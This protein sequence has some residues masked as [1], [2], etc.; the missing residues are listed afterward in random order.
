MVELE[1]DDNRT[2]QEGS[3][4]GQEMYE[5]R[6]RSFISDLFLGQFK[7]TVKCPCGRISKKF[8]PSTLLTL[9]IP[10]TLYI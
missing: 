7:A 4:L 1:D 2:D 10:T 6:N 5:K 3:R 8:D 9:P